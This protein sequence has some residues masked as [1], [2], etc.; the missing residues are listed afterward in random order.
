MAEDFKITVNDLLSSMIFKNALVVAGHQGLN[1]SI[2]WVHI[3]DYPI[4]D[5]L[6]GG[7]FILSTGLMFFDP[8]VAAASL[9]QIIDR[10]ASGLC[11]ELI[12]YL[13]EI[14]EALI[15][16]AEENDFP[17]IVFREYVSFIE[18]TR[19]IHTMI[20]NKDSLAFSLRE[21]FSQELNAVLNAP[22][23][24]EDILKFVQRFLG[25]NFAYVPLPGHPVFLPSLPMPEQS[26]LLEFIEK[27]SEGETALSETVEYFGRKEAIVCRPIEAFNLKKA[28]LFMFSLTRELTEL[29][30]LI[31]D[32]VISAISHDLLRDLFVK[33]K[34]RHEENRWIIDWC[35][36]TLKDNDLALKLKGRGFPAGISAYLVCVLKFEVN[37]DYN[38]ELSELVMHLMILARAL[39]EQEGC[40]FLGTYEE[41][42]IIMVLLDKESRHDRKEKIRRIFEKLKAS[43][44]SFPEGVSI[45]IGIGRRVKQIDGV[46]RS[47]QTAEEAIEIQKTAGRDE[48][49]YDDLHIYRL[50]SL[51]ARAGYL[52]EYVADY[53]EPVLQYD[54]LHHTDLMRTL[55]V[56]CECNGSKQ[57]TAEKLFIVR[58]TLYPRLEKLE[59]LLGSNFMVSEKRLAIEFAL[60]AVH[61][62]EIANSGEQ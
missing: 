10:H 37:P 11:I 25:V 7:E 42:T 26:R 13:Q 23:D 47:Y 2:K 9:K 22:H 30:L 29:E 6:N 40:S 24:V 62:G 41:D 45:S 27:L 14:P 59:E 57:K 36:G 15:K 56:Y 52:D 61:Y 35:Q 50:V 49:F 8:A 5:S 4:Y 48:P 44:T 3:M 53:L 43:R 55:L 28:D 19:E 46:K 20:I 21:K 1:R 38:R 18:I 31:F 32:K 39:F 60:Y 34:K 12:S 58:Q 17:L 54:R 16:L 51:V 33:E